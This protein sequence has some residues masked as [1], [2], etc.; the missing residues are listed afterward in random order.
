METNKTAAERRE[1]HRKRMEERM[2]RL[3]A[4]G[5]THPRREHP[6][7]EMAARTNPHREHP[8]MT[9]LRKKAEEVAQNE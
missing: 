9:H 3:A 6:R 5:R 2:A 7:P 8:F 1:E 4:N